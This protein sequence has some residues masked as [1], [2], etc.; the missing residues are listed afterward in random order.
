MIEQYLKEENIVLNFRETE[1]EK[2]HIVTGQYSHILK[3]DDNNC[4][5][6]YQVQSVPESICCAISNDGGLTFKKPENNYVLQNSLAC[7]NF[8]AFIDD[9]LNSKTKFKAIGGHHCSNNFPS[10]KDCNC[11]TYPVKECYNPV[12]PNKKRTFFIDDVSHPCQG[13]GYYIWESNDGLK[14]KVLSERPVFS[15]FSKMK[16]FDKLGY[17]SADGCPFMFYDDNISEYVAY[18][19][20]NIKLGVRHISYSKS[21]DLLKWSEPELI[22][23]NPEFNFNHDNLYYGGIYKYPGEINKYVAFPS[24]FK[25]IIHNYETG[26][27]RTYLDECTL[28]MIS[29]DGLNWKIKDKWFEGITTNPQWAGHMRAPHV[30]GFI[31]SPDKEEFWLYI[32]KDFLTDHNKLYRYSISKEDFDKI[33]N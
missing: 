18:A 7:H 28:V 24:Y 19:R 22:K 29:N 23:L 10:H 30:L 2:K 4:I 32:Q 12:W 17:I 3:L 14:W 5:L 33:F 6:Y 1:H 20:V 15:S 25:N 11:K 27:P 16:E 21:K 26:E 13:N 8:K 9:N 31:E